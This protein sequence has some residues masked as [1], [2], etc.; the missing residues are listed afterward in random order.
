MKQPLNR[1]AAL[2]RKN[3]ILAGAVALTI[4]ALALLLLKNLMRADGA[5]AQ[6]GTSGESHPLWDA[7]L[8]LAPA[9][10]A[11]LAWSFALQGHCPAVRRLL[12]SSLIGGLALGALGFLAGFVGPMIFSPS[13]NMGPLYGV[14]TGSAGFVVGTLVGT[15]YGW[16]RTP[17][18]GES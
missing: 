12:K 7:A 6:P 3:R 16:M 9:T 17:A 2:W 10:L 14:I 8:V 13:N 1:E 15:L 18:T 5:G 4:S 11:A